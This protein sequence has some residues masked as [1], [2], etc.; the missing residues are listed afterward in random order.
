M[1]QTE[2]PLRRNF[3]GLNRQQLLIY[4]R[5][6]GEHRQRERGLEHTISQREQQMRELA[7]A[8]IAAQEEERQYIAFEVHDRIAQTLA[9]A[10]QQLQ[11]LE[12]MTQTD[13]KTRQVA[14]RASSLVREAIR[15]SRNIMNDLHPPVLDEF[16]IAPLIEEELRSFQE[17]THCQVR[18]DVDYP[19]RPP[20]DVEMALYRIF[21]EALINIRRHAPGARKVTVSL[22]YTGQAVSLQVQDDGPGFDVE[23]ALQAKRV[24]GLMSMRRR[25][26]ILGG[27]FEIISSLSQGTRVSVLVPVNGNNRKGGQGR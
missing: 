13:P 5:E 22:A 17:Q 26:D 12:S 6:L 14:V 19:K 8:S 11:T 23:E 27:Q 9:A 16:G 15:E 24:G 3:D 7:A 18:F 1:R 4:A 25:A 10:F 20:S 21:H 2:I